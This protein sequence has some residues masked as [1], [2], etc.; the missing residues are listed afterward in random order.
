LCWTLGVGQILD[1]QFDEC[2]EYILYGVDRFDDLAGGGEDPFPN[3]ACF[4]FRED[5]ARGMAA[6]PTLDRLNHKVSVQGS[7]RTRVIY[8]A[9]QLFGHLPYSVLLSSGWGGQD[10][11]SALTVDPLPGQQKSVVENL[12]PNSL[13]SFSRDE[14]LA[15]S[16]EV[17]SFQSSAE[18][19]FENLRPV[20]EERIMGDIPKQALEA[21][22]GK[23]DGKP[24]TQ[25]QMNQ[26]A[27]EVATRFIRQL[28]RLDSETP[29]PPFTI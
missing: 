22:L 4:D 2:R 6:V 7:S 16:V 14:V 19:I 17:E 21:V 27:H 28:H 5:L 13:P 25:E 11:C 15:H 10:F 26:L 8:A 18:A 3:L 23:P 29:L 9:V 1:R 12:P 24:V 20:I